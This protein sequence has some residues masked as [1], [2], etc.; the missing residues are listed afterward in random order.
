MKVLTLGEALIDVVE[1]GELASEHV[2]GSPLNVAVG[3]AALGHDSVLATWFGRDRRGEAIRDQAQAAGVHLLPGSDG[4]EKTSVAYARLDQ[5][6]KATYT[7]D[8]LPDLPPVPAPETY[9]HL[10]TGSIAA[11]LEPGG[12]K[13]VAALRAA[14][15]TVS[16]DPNIRPDLMVSP[17]VVRPRIEE[18]IGLSTVV[19]AS[20][21]D[22][23]WLYPGVPVEHVMADWLALGPALVVVTRGADGSSALLRSDGAVIDVA[24]RRVKVADTVGAG[25]SFM[26]GLISGLLDAGFLGGDAAA[27]AL[28]AA[29]WEE[30]EPAIV[31]A[32]RTSSLT[33]ERYGAYAPTRTE[34]D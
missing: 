19:K 22:I 32:T 17:E 5:S 20:D 18:I 16:Y 21:E 26:A 7:F 31:R 3:L 25:D 15:G 24:P 34:L 11:T 29:S 1:E 6:K 12:S 9:G 28:A 14:S 4:A 27:G 33:V 30:V 2:G 23:D 10:H 8:L 13:I